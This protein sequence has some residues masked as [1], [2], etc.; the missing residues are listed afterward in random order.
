MITILDGGMGQ[1]LVKRASRPATPIWGAQVL[2]DEPHLVREIH[3]EYFAAGAEIATTATYAVHRD[4]LEPNDYGHRLAELHETACRMAIE[5]RDAHGSG[6]IAGSLGPLGYTYISDDGPPH[7]EAKRLFAEIAAIQAQFV[8]VLLAESIPSLGRA[9]PTIDGLEGHGKP[10]WIAI[11]V[12]DQDGARL[13]S[14][15]PVTDI[16]GEIEGRP[17]EA[18]LVNCSFP[19]AVSQA[20]EALSGA[21]VPLGGYAN[22]FTG[23]PDAYLEKGSTVDLLEARKDLT[24]DAY[25]GFAETWASLGATIIGGCCEV[26][27]AHI[28]E[29]ARRL[30]GEERG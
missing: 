6:L 12:D 16:L 10:I 27:P 30:S 25:A 28:A 9:R 17:V 14:G 15:E 13:R 2:I 22:G 5:S 4:R 18:L 26:G 8:D 19:E 7:E 23:I 1:E 3:D 11:T 24:P 29:T 20:L 21:P